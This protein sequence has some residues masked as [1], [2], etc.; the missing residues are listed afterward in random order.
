MDSMKNAMQEALKHICFGKIKFT[1]KRGYGFIQREN[2]PDVFFHC[3]QLEDGDFNELNIG[4]NVQFKIMK[5]QKGISA[6]NITVM[7][8]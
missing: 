8:E 3:S 1:C 4:D 5:N 6:V 7:K 2:E